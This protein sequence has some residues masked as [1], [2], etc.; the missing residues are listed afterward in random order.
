MNKRTFIK[1]LG[2]GIAALSGSNLYLSAAPARVS[3]IYPPRIRK[4]DTVGIITPSSPLLS[5]EGYAIADKNI[6][7]L[8][9][10]I[11]WGQHVGQK[12]GHLAGKDEDRIADIHRMFADP[13]VKAIVCLRGGS[14]STR[15]LDKLDYGLIAR[16]PKIFLGYSDITAFHQAIHTQ[17]GLVTFHGA[18]ANSVWTPMVIEQFEQLFFYGKVPDYARLEMQVHAKG[19]LQ[20]AIQTITPGIAEGKLLGGNLTVLTTL[21]GSTYFPDFEDSILFLEDVGEEPYRIDRML[22]QLA[23]SG[24]LGKIKGFIFGKC[25]DCEARYPSK[26]LTLEQILNDYVLALGIPAYQGALIGHIDEQLILPVGAR[27][28]IDAAKGSITVLD[29]IF[30]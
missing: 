9:L 17:T 2:M 26:S 7:K 8:G 15:L 19:R 21:A 12:Y 13:D 23:L 14:G 5:D 25:T 4:G 6:S 1:T 3:S 18:V 29:N 10:R 16:N 24:A 28:R 11:K 27:V 22:S 30:R 20:R